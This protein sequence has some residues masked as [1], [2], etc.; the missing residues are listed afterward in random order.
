MQG[1]AYYTVSCKIQAV[2]GSEKLKAQSRRRGKRRGPTWDAGQVRALRHH[3]GLSQQ[4]LAEE[5]GTRQ[6][7]VSEWETSR[8]RPRGT[9]TRLLT[10]IAERAGFQYETGK[11]NPGNRRRGAAG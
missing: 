7:T 3:L 9:S 1:F 2:G 5:L 8:Y 4:G 11:S 6:Q 10:I